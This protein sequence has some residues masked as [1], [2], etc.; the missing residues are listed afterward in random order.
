MTPGYGN[1]EL[2]FEVFPIA[3]VIHDPYP[4]GIMH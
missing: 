2:W 1:F 4:T 3:E